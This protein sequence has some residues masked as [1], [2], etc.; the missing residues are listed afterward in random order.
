M[1]IEIP[2]DEGFVLRG[3][4]EGPGSRRGVVVC[5][6]HPAFG[7]TLDTPVVAALAAGLVKAGGR[8]LRFNFRG[9]GGSGGTPQGGLAEFRDVVAAGAFLVGQGCQELVL[10]GYSF[11]ALMALGALANGLQARAVVA[12]GLPTVVMGEGSTR[13]GSLGAAL[14]S[15]PAL[16]VSGTADQF[17][18]LGRLRGWLAP[19]AQAELQTL[20]EVGH[21]Y[22]GAVLEEVVDR[23]VRWVNGRFL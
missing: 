12:L 18:E 22:A 11:G 9:V 16:F 17:C 1:L 3:V 13:W 10:V 21:F 23:M 5:H 2:T 15:T 19:F 14:A 7:G 4:L 20:P 8:V 6:P